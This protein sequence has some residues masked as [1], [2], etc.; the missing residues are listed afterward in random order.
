MRASASSFLLALPFQAAMAVDF[1]P[2]VELLE[3]GQVT[4]QPKGLGGH[5]G[6]CLSVD[7]RSTSSTPLRTSIPA[8][9][10]FVSEIPDVQDL[11][12]VREEAIALAPHGQATVTCRAFCCEAENAGPDA[13]EAYRKGHPA[14]KKL[15]ALAQMV[16]SSDYAD[17]L[18]QSAVWVLSNGHDIASLGALDGTG[19]DT[20]RNK[21]SLLS[22]QPAPRYTVRYAPS[23]HAACS[24][25]PES[26]S[27]VIEFITGGA[28]RLT[29]IVK[30][31]AGRLME[32][33]YDRELMVPGEY[34][35]PVTAHVLDWPKGRYA[36]Y[37]YSDE[38]SSVRRLPFVL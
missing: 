15:L 18:V 7:V 12:V 16:D 26:I 21:L 9:W 1:T 23:E 34:T 32:V 3:R 19:E 17:N 25:R 27:R 38:A 20:L 35:M 29:V 14:A 24:G 33:M 11:I 28:Q 36:F 6:D 37:V 13:G 5:S 30:N 31:D 2:L 4:L 22:G 8:G 10:V